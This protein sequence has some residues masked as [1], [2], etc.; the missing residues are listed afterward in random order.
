MSRFT[1]WIGKNAD[2]V[3]ALVLAFCIAILASLDVL[4]TAQVN[5]AV[6][7]ILAVLA[8]TLLRDRVRSSVL[9]QDVT[10][11]I[12]QLDRLEDR[13]TG[14]Q[15]ALDQASNLR[16]L[17]GNAIGQAL[18]TARKDTESWMFKGGTGTY[19]RAVTLP[20]C[21]ERARD[22][23]RALT[24]RL[25]ILDPTNEEVCEHYAGY[26]RSV[27]TT[28][29]GTGE[30]WTAGRTAKE[31][32]ATILAACWYR[33]RY[34]L[35]TVEVG[36]SSTITTF[37]WDVSSRCVI[38]T[39]LI[40]QEDPREPALLIERGST[41]YDRYATELLTSLEQSRRLPIEQAAKAAQLSDEPSVEETQ[42]LFVALNL[43]LPAAFDDVAISEIIRKA[44]QAKDPY[45]RT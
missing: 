42:K 31:S 19:I 45:A 22:E 11:V 40:T 9:E 13:V 5:S 17:R 44:I 32:F 36:L 8:A 35:L 6:L 37:R 18:A 7:L 3:I 14:T 2:G 1:K 21:I 41:Y 16:V 38:M 4:G 33:Q 27:S 23:G 43:P 34:R 20:E 39:Q 30:V 12:G 26:Q 29:D 25:E 10:K 15:H 28:L 24:M